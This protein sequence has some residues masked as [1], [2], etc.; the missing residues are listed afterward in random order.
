MKGVIHQTNRKRL[1]DA[2][3]GSLIILSGYD[4]MQWTGDMAIPF[5]QEASFWWASGIEEPG[6]RMIIDG[7]RGKTTLVRPEVSDIQKIFDG[8]VTDEQV[9]GLSGADAVIHM[10]D[11]ERTLR[12]LARTH[13]VAL[14]I[15]AKHP[16]EFIANPAQ[17]VLVDVL[18]RHFST[19]QDCSSEL[20]ELRA[21]KLP[22]EIALIRKAVKLTCLAFEHVRNSLGGYRHEYEIE[23]EFS[24]Y[25]RR[26]NA[27][28]A[29]EPIVGSGAR[30]CTLHYTAN[31]EKL[32][33]RSAVLIDIGARIGGYSADI[34]RT[35][36]ARPTKRQMQVH[37]VL[38]RAHHAIIGTLMPG[39]PV[40]EYQKEVDNI[41]KTA[42]VELGLLRATDDEAAYRRYFPHA[43]SHG[44]GIDTHDPL[45]RPRYFK[46]GMVITVEPGIYITDE[47]VG[48]RI[49]DDV[50]ITGMGHEVLSASL[51][52]KL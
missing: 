20:H 36:C 44:L 50:L 17:S 25:F 6:W 15:D 4:A 12:Q 11:M 45:G 19:V 13:S 3:K 31:S 14:T 30:A 48:M 52:T 46:E 35:Y 39:L 43:I 32:T 33:S 42:L 16:H 22:E 10:R 2:T 5:R 18:K 9:L 27:V 24:A 23:A 21:I 51:S 38:E 49:E 37:A 29:Y 40:I 41:M 7:V 26:N 8:G 28:H 34:T 47:S 1:V